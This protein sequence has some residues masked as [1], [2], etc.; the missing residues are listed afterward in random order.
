MVPVDHFECIDNFLTP[1][2]MFKNIHFCTSVNTGENENT[3]YRL[4]SRINCIEKF[5]DRITIGSVILAP[6]ILFMHDNRPGI[7][8][9][10]FFRVIKEKSQSRPGTKAFTIK[11]A[12]KNM[13]GR[14][15]EVN[16]QALVYPSGTKNTLRFEY[17]LKL[18]ADGNI[19]NKRDEC[20]TLLLGQRL[21]GPSDHSLGFS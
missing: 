21:S 9:Q 3:K 14:L 15:I 19:V 6:E 18:F 5:N 1:D 16:L 8:R 2:F 17:V 10:E 12:S 11:M 20:K 13:I 4:S 7:D